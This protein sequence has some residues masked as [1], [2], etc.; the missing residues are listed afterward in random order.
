[1]SAHEMPVLLEGPMDADMTGMETAMGLDEVDLF[2]DPV[3]MARPR[4]SKHVQQRLDELRARG[5]CQSI[6]WS[7]QGT[8]ASISK[9]GASIELRFLRCHPDS[10]NWGL[11]AP[12]PYPYLSPTPG[13]VPITHLAWAP[14]SSPE[15]AIIDAVG[16]INI[17]SFS[18][19]LNRPYGGRR[20]ETDAVDDLNAVVGCYWLPLLATPGR[21]YQI[22]YGPATRNQSEYKFETSVTP[23]S[24]PWHP[25]SG[26]SALLCVTTSGFL[27]L[28]FSQ[29][30][31]RIEETSLELDSVTSSDDLITHA[32]ICSEKSTSVSFRSPSLIGVLTPCRDRHALDCP[33]HGLE[34]A[35]SGAGEH[36]MGHP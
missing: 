12:S 21:Q 26:K 5:C 15:L 32:S 2:G 18:I 1:M 20:W 36:P 30:N 25:N 6:A 7:R 31:N 33:C 10:G 4:A 34:T 11:S 16:R 23:A 14:T 8:I 35:Q 17:L 24:G 28:I 27:K 9:D 19:T 29:N 13:G 22:M 3:V